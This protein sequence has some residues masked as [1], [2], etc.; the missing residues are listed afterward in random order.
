MRSRLGALLRR[1]AATRRQTRIELGL[2]IEIPRE[3]GRSS[4][5]VSRW[6]VCRLVDFRHNPHVEIEQSH[7][8][9]KKVVSA[10]SIWSTYR[11]RVVAR[12]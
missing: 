12:N 2:T 1:G 5:K 6:V 4:T 3:I 9:V 11:A 10:D 8:D 7:G